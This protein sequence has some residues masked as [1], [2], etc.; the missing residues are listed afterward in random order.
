MNI[1]KEQAEVTTKSQASRLL[2][3]NWLQIIILNLIQIMQNPHPQSIDFLMY[4]IHCWHQMISK[5]KCITVYPS[6]VEAQQIL[7]IYKVAMRV[8]QVQIYGKLKKN[9]KV[10][11]KNIKI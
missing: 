5:R 2:N 7:L 3:L 4:Y 10:Y 6:S 11:F 9:T 1:N 8:I